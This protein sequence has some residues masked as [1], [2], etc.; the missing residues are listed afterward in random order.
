MSFKPWESVPL[1][2]PV[3][4]PLG[5][6]YA[7]VQA[8]RRRRYARNPDLVHRFD[9]PVIS[10]GNL[11]VGGTGK[12]PF[13]DLVL[14]QLPAELHPCL[15]LGH[16]YGARVGPETDALDEEGALIQR[17]HP[18]AI[19]AQ[20]KDRVAAA[21][22]HLDRVSSII[23]DDGAQHLRIARDLD[24]VLF[25]AAELAGPRFVLPAGPWREELEAAKG[26]TL[27]VLT[28]CDEADPH[29]LARA[30]AILKGRFPGKPVLETRHAATT[31]VDSE[32]RVGDP[33]GL[34]GVEIVL[35]SGI[36]RPGSFVRS[37]E[38][39][40]ARIGRRLD[41]G[42][43]H[44]YG[45]DDVAAIEA[46]LAEL[47]E[48]PLVTTGK[49]APKLERLLSPAAR[50][51]LRILHVDIEILSGREELESRLAALVPAAP[52]PG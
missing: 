40:G 27:Y 35:V 46:R 21:A 19:V 32:G 36:A 26:A 30:R 37:V 45:S 48:A 42:D 14:K 22:P 50:E 24:I 15:V 10:I 2:G 23:L 3:L 7:L 17:R 25:D 4:A 33:D 20:G 38:A 43:H 51:R 12:T 39:L 31:L 52:V 29:D 44:D 18:E 41:F 9:L 6:L 11:V 28:R 47:P 16:G 34:V 8:F 1:W 5:G 49:D 13:V